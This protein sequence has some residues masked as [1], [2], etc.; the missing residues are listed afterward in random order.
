[1]SFDVKCYE[2]AVS[3][4]SDEPKLQSLSYK[5]RLS[6]AIQDTIESEIEAFRR[7]KAGKDKQP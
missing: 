4:L 6:Q 2:L 3:F 1:M 5:R 7:E